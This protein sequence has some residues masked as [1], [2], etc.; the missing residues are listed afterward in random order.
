MRRKINGYRILNLV[1]GTHVEILSLSRKN[2]SKG[3]RA[4]GKLTYIASNFSYIGIQGQVAKKK[5]KLESRSRK[6]EGGEVES[7]GSA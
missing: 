6:K 3:R 5:R 7:G 1:K 2:P 4:G